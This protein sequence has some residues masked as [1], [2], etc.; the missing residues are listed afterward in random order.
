MWASD[1]VTSCKWEDLMSALSKLAFSLNLGT[2]IC[3]LMAG[4]Q[5]HRNEKKFNLQRLGM[6]QWRCREEMGGRWRDWV[7]YLLFVV[8][9]HRSPVHRHCSASETTGPAGTSSICGFSTW[10]KSR[11]DRDQH[12]RY[13]TKIT[14]SVHDKGLQTGRNYYRKTVIVQSNI[15]SYIAAIFYKLNLIN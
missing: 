2:S 6:A 5:M 12:V 13:H 15:V 4:L 14:L 3:C 1:C 10:N 7:L 9:V 11:Q 8:L